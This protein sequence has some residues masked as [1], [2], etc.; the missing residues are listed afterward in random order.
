MK[1]KNENAQIENKLNRYRMKTKIRTGRNKCDQ[2]IV[3]QSF[4]ST[5]SSIQTYR[6]IYG[7]YTY[8]CYNYMQAHTFQSLNTVHE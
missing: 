7:T 8:T 4:S 6:Y 3:Q 2:E 5:T 1:K